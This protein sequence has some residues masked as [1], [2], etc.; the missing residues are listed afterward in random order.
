MS[1]IL[2][3]LFSLNP[4]L[5]QTIYYPG[6]PGTP[7][8]QS[9]QTLY[10]DFPVGPDHPGA[11]FIDY[12]TTGTN[13]SL[14]KSSQ[15]QATFEVNTSDI[16]TFGYHSEDFNTCAYPAHA[17]DGDYRWWSNPMA[18]AL[19]N[20]LF[21]LTVPLSPAQW[22]NVWGQFGNTRAAQFN[23]ALKQPQRIGFS[24]GGGCFFGHGVNASEPA[25]FVLQSFGVN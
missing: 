20:G 12:L 15:I 10:F 3:L 23:L 5:W 1:I 4:A 19:D 13:G 25:Q 24:F 17:Q 21:T 8:Q 18:V 6:Y 7:P 9:G 14:S 11:D 22:S 16:T 2:A